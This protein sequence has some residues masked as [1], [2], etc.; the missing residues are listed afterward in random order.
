TGEQDRG[1][2]LRAER[3]I[4]WPGLEAG[5]I[6]DERAIV[7]PCDR[8]TE[9]RHQLEQGLDV[10]DAWDIAD[11][12]G[13]IGEQRGRDDRESCILVAGRADSAAKLVTAVDHEARRHR[14]KV[15]GSGT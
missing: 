8:R 1:A 11:L 7:P 10:A 9:E 6:D 3:W 12:D 13:A 4:E 2:N 5:G 15:H 14:G